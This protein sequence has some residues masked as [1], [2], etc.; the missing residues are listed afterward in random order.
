MKSF[1]YLSKRRKRWCMLFL[2]SDHVRYEQGSEW[3]TLASMDWETSE[4]S[5]GLQGSTELTPRVLLL[6]NINEHVGTLL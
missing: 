6:L 5:V 3:L 2:N 4:D 1:L